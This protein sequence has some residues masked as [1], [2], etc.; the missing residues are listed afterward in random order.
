MIMDNLE[1]TVELAHEVAKA[2]SRNGWNKYDVS[3]L[4]EG[5]LL[6]DVL[7]VVKGHAFIET[8]G[9]I[10]DCDADPHIPKEGWTVER[11]ER[12]GILKWDKV[13]RQI[14]HSLG[15]CTKG[16]F[17]DVPFNA[18]VLFHLYNNRHLIPQEW[19]GKE[20]TF[21]GTTYRH[22]YEVG[23]DCSP[24]CVCFLDLA[25]GGCS[26]DWVFTDK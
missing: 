18:N 13:E 22:N 26:W 8:K 7:R 1:M 10:I 19:K 15:A 21:R 16:R 4:S 6:A 25:G 23:D 14:A 3:R 11:H 9:L 20:I 5:A 2:F 17:V 24:L 12:G